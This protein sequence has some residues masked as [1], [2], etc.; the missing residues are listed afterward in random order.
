MAGITAL[1]VGTMGTASADQLQVDGDVLI[2]S[3]NVAATCIA[4]TNDAQAKL[5]YQGS[6]HFKSNQLLTVT[7]TPDAPITAS[8]SSGGAAPTTLSLGSWT[9][10][11][12]D[13]TLNFRT[14]VPANTAGGT[15]KVLVALTGQDTN[16][17]TSTVDDFFNVNVTCTPPT[18]TGPVV[19]AL[20][21]S[22]AVAEGATATNSGTWSDANA[23]DS[24]SLSASVG[25]VVKSGT[26]S[27]GTLVLVLRHYGWPRAVTVSC[28][29]RQRWDDH[30]DDLL[31][32]H[33]YQRGADCD[34][35]RRI[36]LSLRP[37]VS[38]SA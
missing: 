33:S 8:D 34:A 36:A 7:I 24:V 25:T 22:V 37:Q 2:T 9:S 31:P 29:H 6:S 30:D 4:E 1:A 10:S 28:H 16:N 26:N 11:S 18:N 27:G 35:R 17:V 21:G 19:V 3:S 13:V 14:S 38:L 5:T 32:A 12:L 20:N 23:G 15:Y